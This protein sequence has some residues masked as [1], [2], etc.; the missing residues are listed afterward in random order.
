MNEQS[1]LSENEL[2][3]AIEHGKVARDSLQPTSDAFKCLD[4]LLISAKRSQE[5]QQKLDEANNELKLIRVNLCGVMSSERT[6]CETYAFVEGE[7]EK[8]YD[9]RIKAEQSSREKDEK[10]AKLE[11]HLAFWSATF[12]KYLSFE[13]NGIKYIPI[14]QVVA[15]FNKCDQFLNQQKEK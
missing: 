15:D 6:D 8:Q 14:K 7:I 1:E 4:A 2:A 13:A 5:L 10:I 9:L 3:K 11:L 12:S